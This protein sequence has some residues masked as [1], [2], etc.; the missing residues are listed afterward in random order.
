[1]RCSRLQYDIPRLPRYSRSSI[2]TPWPDDLR[3]ILSLVR[4]TAI[5]STTQTI[6][7][8]RNPNIQRISRRQ[9]R[10]NLPCRY[11]SPTRSLG[12]TPSCQ[13]HTPEEAAMGCRAEIRSRAYIL[14]GRRCLAAW[15]THQ[16][17]LS[18][19][20]FCGVV[21]ASYH[22]VV[23]RELRLGACDGQTVG[24]HELVRRKS[25]VSGATAQSV[26]VRQT[27][28]SEPRRPSTGVML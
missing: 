12:T 2:S 17:S 9:R 23:P 27:E 7:P 28:S 10:S 6:S 3:S 4:K 25:S 14:N 16:V 21:L 11:L 22:V 18:V 20:T 26:F 24:L 1:M 13:A 8:T 19:H 15:G 5:S